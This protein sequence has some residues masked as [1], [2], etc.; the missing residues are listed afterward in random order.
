MTYSKTINNNFIFSV[1]A[2]HRSCHKDQKNGWIFIKTSV[3]GSS[4]CVGCALDKAS[5]AAQSVCSV[6]V[7]S[8][9]LRI[10]QNVINLPL[11]NISWHASLCWVIN[12]SHCCHYREA[13]RS[14]VVPWC[15]P[16][17]RYWWGPE[18]HPCHQL[19]A[20]ATTNRPP[21]TSP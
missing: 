18:D 21:Q 11:D 6:P 14:I 1:C 10:Q 17:T 13:Y 9:W 15:P 2:S 8:L 4:K 3:H 7:I 20:P 12:I 16:P 19:M 5:F